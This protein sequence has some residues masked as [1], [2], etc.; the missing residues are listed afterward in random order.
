MKLTERTSGVLLHLSSLPGASFCGDMGQ[1]ARDFADFLNRSGQI[2]WQMLPINPIDSYFSP[3]ASIS[4]FAGDPIYIDLCALLQDGLLDSSDI[5]W[6]PDG[7]IEKTAFTAARDFR[8]KRWKKA[9]HRFQNHKGG[10][11]YWAAYDEFMEKNRDWALRHALFC[12]LAEEY[13]TYHW[14]LWPNE[15]VRRAD[16][17]VVEQICLEKKDQIA[18]HIFLQLVFSVQWRAFRNYCHEKG[19]GLIG[20]VPIYVGRASADTWGQTQLFQMDQDGQMD[21]VAG[22][23]GDSFNPDGQ[24]WD[25]PL[26]DWKVHKQEGYQWWSSRIRTLFARFDV[27]RLDHFIGFYNYYSMPNV[28]DPKDPGEWIPGPADDFFD[29][30]LKEFPR[31][32]FIAEDLGVMNP[33]VHAL[34][35][36]YEFPGINVFQFFF[37]FRRSS[38]PTREWKTNSYVC[39][40]THDTTTLAAWLD[41]VIEDRRKAEPFWNFNAIL[42]MLK[43][44]IP[45]T[46][47]WEQRLTEITP[48]FAEQQRNLR[49]PCFFDSSSDDCDRKIH[50]NSLRWAIIQMILDSPG[51]TAIFPM[52]DLIGL[53]KDAR[54]NFPGRIDSNWIW[55]L[56]PKYLNEALEHTLFDLAVAYQR[57]KL[58]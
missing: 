11:T 55:R 3:Y 53:G 21:R 1:G 18:Y 50:R 25:S 34:R 45:Q 36:K 46:P 29:T 54:M 38:D 58:E 43:R 52:Q 20:D 8:K 32:S 30:I 6:Q 12:T 14:E 47:Q 44:F 19:V 5:D 57:T 27:V 23:P 22:V 7:P 9:F 17:A 33:G 41:E 48:F 37:D 13:G 39:S 28:P 42:G 56:H 26:Y 15:K 16:P 49:F 24:R 31:T 2:W 35:D 40:G 10:D 4:A 51:N